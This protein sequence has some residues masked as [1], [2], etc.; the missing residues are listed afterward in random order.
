MLR[1]SPR[2]RPSI[3]DALAHPSLQVRSPRHKLGGRA[4]RSF[5]AVSRG[6]I[7]QSWYRVWQAFISD[8]E[9]RGAYAA[10]STASATAFDFPLQGG[11]R[12]AR[13]EYKQH[14]FER[15]IKVEAKRLDRMR[16]FNAETSC[17][18]CVL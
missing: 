14:L 17:S 13:G 1:F 5:A 10:A 18:P 2:K 3:A 15:M 9:R 11:S 8:D 7:V 16:A 6:M 4:H 12:A